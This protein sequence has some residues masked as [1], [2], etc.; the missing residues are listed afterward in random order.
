M[1]QIVPLKLIKNAGKAFQSVLNNSLKNPENIVICHLNVNSLSNK[2]E[3]VEE[4]VQNKIDTCFLS[5]TKIDGTFPNQ[6][7]MIM[8]IRYSAETEIVMVEAFY[9]IL[10]K[11]SPPK[12]QM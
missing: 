1:K 5:E 4:P 10:I 2:F 9:V 12:L 7:F 3:A 8:V 11:I 6:Q